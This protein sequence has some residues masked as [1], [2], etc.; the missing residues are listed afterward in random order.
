[1]LVATL[2][3][4]TAGFLH[5]SAQTAHKEAPGLAELARAGKL[6]PV[7]QRLPSDPLVIPVV[8]KIGSYG[9]IWRRAFLGP[10]DANNYVRVVY[11]ALFRF[12]PD[13]TKIEPKVAAGSSASS[14]FKVW[15]I[16]LRKG[17]RWSDGEKF[18]V[19]DI[20]F[21]Y[22]DILLVKD[23][24]P[25]LPGWIRNADGSVALVEKLD[26]YTI[27]FTYKEPATLFLT[28]VANQDGSDR[29]YAMF[30]PAHYL[31]KFHPATRAAPP[32]NPDRP[33]M[34]AWAPISRVSDPVFTLRR[35]PYFVGIDPAG[36]QLPY[37]DE[38]RFTYFA[39]V[40]A[41][42]LAAIAGNFDM[43]AR[44]ILMTN[45]PVFKDQEKAGK[46]RV[47]TWP[48]FGGADAVLAFNLTYKADPVLGELMA[49]KGFRQALS[50]AVN[51]DEIKESVFLGLGEARQGVPG[52]SHPYF[53]GEEWASKYTEYNPDEANKLLDGLGLD[54]RDPNGVRLMKNGKPAIIEISVVPAFGAWPDVAQ[55]I[56]KDWERVGIKPIVQLRERALHFSMRESNELQTEIWNEGT[57]GF[58]F[59]GNAQFDPRNSPILTLGPLFN[60]WAASNGKE[61][62]EPPAGIKRIMQLVDT[63]RTVDEAGQIKAA[64]ELFRIWSDGVYEIGTIG[65]TPMVQGVVVVG[66]K[67]RNVPATLSND[68]PLRTPGNARPEQFFF[69]P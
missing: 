29:T 19:D 30:Q 45:Y 68:W 32:E 42:N 33:T 40:Q 27:R 39:D 21:W 44:H 41:L 66:N 49:T 28:A 18:T 35:N 22:K 55:L 57:T 46:Y 11:D 65:L 64:Q 50:I 24:T 56:A 13:G 25:V 47:M 12:S 14:D 4:A 8:E 1:M 26:D 59:T 2:I 6:P 38:V 54:K 10:A 3:A 52:A 9:G 51:R 37:L 20:L 53:P 34:A 15:T 31:K 5:A 58:P 16:T 48:A 60:K 36:N 67:F 17:A 7:D 43:Q 61:G 63:A 23:L 69:A 62:V